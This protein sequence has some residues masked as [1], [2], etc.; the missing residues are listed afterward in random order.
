M[1]SLTEA[2]KSSVS[3]L[4][5]LV[6]EGIGT[7]LA[8]EHKIIL[9]YT[10]IQTRYLE[11][12]RERVEGYMNAIDMLD[13]ER[14][15]IYRLLNPPEMYSF[16]LYEQTKN[17]LIR[18]A[19]VYGMALNYH[20]LAPFP[21]FY[22]GPTDLCAALCC[23][24][25]AHYYGHPATLD[26]IERKSGDDDVYDGMKKKEV[27]KYLKETSFFEERITKSEFDKK[28]FE[29]ITN[30]IQ[31]EKDPIIIAGLDDYYGFETEMGHDVV[32]V[33][34]Y[35]GFGDKG[36]VVA[37]TNV[38]ITG[39]TYTVPWYYILDHL[40]ADIDSFILTEGDGMAG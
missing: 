16:R 36:V 32:I 37:D 18:R 11:S 9:R 25:V 5:A 4:M 24:M 34:Y 8:D 31:D 6:D 38:A 17:A 39:I 1:D 28:T 40:K 21:T 35:H 27:S 22:Q 33:G 26:E 15:L 2:S 10:S 20:E 3:T 14:E 23:K 12:A 30:Q 29:K 7:L 19:S 13:D